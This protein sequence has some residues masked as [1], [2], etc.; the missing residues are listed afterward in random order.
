MHRPLTFHPFV[1]VTPLIRLTCH[2]GCRVVSE[3]NHPC[4]ISCWS[5][6]GFLGGRTPKSAISYTYWNDSYNS[7]ALPCRLWS[8]CRR[9]LNCLI[10]PIAKIWHY[11][12]CSSNIKNRC[13]DP[14]Y[15]HFQEWFVIH[16]LGL[17]T[18]SCLPNSKSLSPPITKIWKV[19][20]NV[21]NGLVWRS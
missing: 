16:G 1:G 9:N 12:D 7:P 5:V 13:R 15:A 3:R 4:Q 8:V 10:S 6:K 19:T 21:E 11:Y 17:A 2:L 18:I 20:Q 14:D